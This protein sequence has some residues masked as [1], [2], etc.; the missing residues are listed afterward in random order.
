MT[1]D[2]YMFLYSKLDMA[3]IPKGIQTKIMNGDEFTKS[4][5]KQLQLIIDEVRKEKIQ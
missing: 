1:A 2:D 5:E 3:K 4:E